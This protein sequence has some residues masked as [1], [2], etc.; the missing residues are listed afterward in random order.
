MKNVLYLDKEE[1]YLDTLLCLQSHVTT[2]TD[3]VLILKHYEETE[4]YECC[5]GILRAI[6]EYKQ[7]I[8]VNK[9][10]TR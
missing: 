6:N 2:L 10:I 5:S 3:V 8:K 7:S 9:A 1:C 4:E